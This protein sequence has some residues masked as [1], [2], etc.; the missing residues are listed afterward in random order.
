MIDY[1]ESRFSSEGA[2]WKFEPSDS[3]FR[4]VEIF[5][6]NNCKKILIPGSG[7]GRNAK[8]FID[9]GFTITGIEISQSAIEIAK[10][11]GLTYKTYHGSVTSMPFDR[12][13]FDGVFCYA[14][15]HLL[16]KPNRKKFLKCCF[17]QLKPGGI[18]IFI[19]ASKQ[20]NMYGEGKRISKDRFEISP[21][22]KVFFYDPESV[23]SEFSEFGLVDFAE[24]L[25]PVK[26]QE[27]LEPLELI[28]IKCQKKKES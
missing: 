24:V 21:G 3:A 26:F 19:T 11:S 5:K 22:L 10:G 12:K 7:Y 8:Q 13:I 20:M 25:E 17:E 6:N 18:M 4:A 15:I 9:S 2:M 1:W 27:G 28:F 16:N 23:L 14:L